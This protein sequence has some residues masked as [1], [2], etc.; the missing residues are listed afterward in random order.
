MIFQIYS[1]IISLNSSIIVLIILSL[2]IISPNLSSVSCTGLLPVCVLS[3]ISSVTSFPLLDRY[4]I[5]CEDVYIPTKGE[6]TLR[7][8]LQEL[9]SDP[10][11]FDGLL[12]FEQHTRQNE[13]GGA[14]NTYRLARGVDLDF[15]DFVVEHRSNH[16]LRNFRD[17]FFYAGL[18]GTAEGREAMSR[19]HDPRRRPEFERQWTPPSEGTCN[20]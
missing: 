7:R 6:C 4:E 11:P 16:I 13:C 10:S 14:Y 18:S 17:R 9:R 1:M 2:E 12:W 15:I 20:S 8:K 5:I 19:R 3:V